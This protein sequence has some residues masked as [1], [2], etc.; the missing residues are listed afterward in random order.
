MLCFCPILYVKKKISGKKEEKCLEPF[1]I[2]ESFQKSETP[3]KIGS[4]FYSRFW[5]EFEYYTNKYVL[6]NIF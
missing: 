3:L 6:N 5:K 2:S 1:S 4:V